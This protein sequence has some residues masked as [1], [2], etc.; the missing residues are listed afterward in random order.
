MSTR[1]LFAFIL[2]LAHDV[3]LTYHRLKR[4]TS[5]VGERTS[6][7]L[8]GT[9]ENVP[10]CENRKAQKGKMGRSVVRGAEVA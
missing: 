4:A 3:H 6:G 1:H 9:R 10:L 5:G 2:N 7:A 8:G